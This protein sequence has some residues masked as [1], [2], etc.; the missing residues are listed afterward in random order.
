MTI[1]AKFKLGLVGALLVSSVSAL[2]AKGIKIK[3]T[4]TNAEDGKMIY[5]YQMLGSEMAKYDSCVIKKSG[6][7]FKGE[8]PRGYYKIGFNAKNNV[9]LILGEESIGIESDAKE[10][11]STEVTE[12]KEWMLQQDFDEFNRDYGTA[13][14]SIQSQVNYA[15]QLNG[16]DPAKAQTLFK[17]IQTDFDSVAAERTTFYNKLIKENPGTYQGKIAAFYLKADELEKNQFFNLPEMDDT[18]YHRGE[19]W[20][21][22]ISTY[23]QKFLMNQRSGHL[24]AAKAEIAK[25]EKGSAKR[26]LLYISMIRNLMAV[27]QQSGSKLGK[28]YRKEYPKSAYQKGLYKLLPP[29]PIGIGDMAPDIA[30]KNP[31]GDQMKLSD[32]RGKVV[33]IDFWASWCG[34]CRRENPNVVKA[35]EKYKDK[36]FTVF[37]VSL[38]KQASRWKGAIAKDKLVWPYHV[39]DLKG[40]SA[41][42]AK[43][44]GVTSIP[45]TFL[46]DKDGVIVARNLRGHALESKLKELLGN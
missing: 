27:D 21:A 38:D 39:S 37:S 23:F 2:Q 1:S 14:Q 26:E 16:R 9:T 3:G 24:E 4:L 5:M 44:Y 41:A 42:P 35:Y 10:M 29:L 45:A 46:I 40:W 18:E 33:L 8:I 13:M 15:R 17:K 25:L 20:V 30:E 43:K 22:L 32:A 11:A 28:E 7:D 19:M 12:S 36:G 31:D 34:P 6:Y